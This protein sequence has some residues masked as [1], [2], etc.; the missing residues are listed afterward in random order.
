MAAQFLIS[1]YIRAAMALAT[2]KHLDDGSVAG[3]IPPCPGVI[4]FAET[5]DRCQIELQS[6]LEEWVWLGL[7]HGHPI[8]VIGGINLSEEPAVA[9]LDSL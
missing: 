6:V 7:K 9:T 8:P 2:Y 4:T 3:R 5:E 1:D